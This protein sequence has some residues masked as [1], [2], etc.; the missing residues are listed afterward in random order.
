MLGDRAVLTIYVVAS[1]PS[2]HDKNKVE[3]AAVESKFPEAQV[4]AVDKDGTL[5]ELILK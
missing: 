4:Y 1:D 3:I 2:N 5:V